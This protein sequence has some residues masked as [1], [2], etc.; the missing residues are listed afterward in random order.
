MES[1]VAMEAD[2]SYIADALAFAAA[3]TQQQPGDKSFLEKRLAE[4]VVS[5]LTSRF[6]RPNLVVRDKKLKSCILPGW[7]PQ[8][9]TID[10]TVITPLREP[11]I[12]FELKVDDV[13]WTLWGLYKMVAASTL[14]TLDAAYLL[15]AAKTTVWSSKREC[16]ELFDFRYREEP[17][18]Q[19]EEAEW[20]SRFLFRHWAKAWRDLLGGG[21]GRL[22]WVPKLIWTRAIGRWAL[23]EFPGYELRAIRTYPSSLSTERIDFEHGWP[24][25]D[26]RVGLLGRP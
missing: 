1:S 2:D 18:G 24:V 25:H 26:L 3:Q 21:T 14:P 10:V 6:F 12:V 11:R 19:L 22:V 17:E 15:V 5:A 8:P 20:Y 9:G 23:P 13:E 7:D 4:A 16:V